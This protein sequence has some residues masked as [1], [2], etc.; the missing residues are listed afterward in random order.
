MV[1]SAAFFSMLGGIWALSRPETKLSMSEKT[2]LAVLGGGLGGHVISKWHKPIGLG[3]AA[4]L[5]GLGLLALAAQAMGIVKS[6]KA[7]A[8]QSGDE[9]LPAPLPAPAVAEWQRPPPVSVVR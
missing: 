6:G 9:A 7:F 4:G 3:I 1:V 5:A 8:M 2:W